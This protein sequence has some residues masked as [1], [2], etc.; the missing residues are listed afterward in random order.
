LV[1]FYSFS[2]ETIFLHSVTFFLY[3][4]HLLTKR[5][6]ACRAF[7]QREGIMHSVST[8]IR[9]LAIAAVVGGFVAIGGM[10]RAF[11]EGTPNP[12]T[13]KAENP[14]APKA[15]NPCAQQH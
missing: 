14:C 12:C 7:I 5:A 9:T 10:A 8:F 4:T 2:K 15:E 1:D 11:A 3:T 13:P 6:C